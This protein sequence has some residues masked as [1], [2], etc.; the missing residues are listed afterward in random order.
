MQQSANQPVERA[1]ALAAELNSRGN[2]PIWDIASHWDGFD[3]RAT[4]HYA[5]DVVVLT[6]GTER[7]LVRRV[8]GEWIVAES[9]E[10]VSR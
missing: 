7:T 2:Q 8:A 5:R 1:E 4:A 10:L 3:A 9:V 6:H